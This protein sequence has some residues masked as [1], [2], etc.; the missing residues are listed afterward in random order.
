[1]VFI[2]TIGIYEHLR[3]VTF[4]SRTHDIFTRLIQA[5][6]SDLA[7]QIGLIVNVDLLFTINQRLRERVKG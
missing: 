4:M 3:I 1:M 6:M 5:T 7:F 2:A